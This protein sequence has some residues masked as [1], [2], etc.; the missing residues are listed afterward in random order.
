MSVSDSRAG[1]ARRDCQERLG[2]EWG[3]NRPASEAT[4]ETSEDLNEVKIL[5]KVS[6]EG[7][8]P[9]SEAT[10]ETSEDLNEVKI[11]EKSENGER[12]ERRDSGGSER[13]EDPRKSERGSQTRLTSAVA[14]QPGGEP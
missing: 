14:W 3:E 11:L 8:R 9:A 4:R 13:S 12:G 6:G 7:H 10:R 1:R 5:E 2:R